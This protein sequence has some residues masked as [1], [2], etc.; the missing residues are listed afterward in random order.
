MSSSYQFTQNYD[1]EDEDGEVT[2]SYD[3]RDTSK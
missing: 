3:G 1:S 2:F